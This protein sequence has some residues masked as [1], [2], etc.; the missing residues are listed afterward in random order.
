[1]SDAIDAWHAFWSSAATISA[2]LFGLTLVTALLRVRDSLLPRVQ[3]KTH[4]Y[5]ILRAYGAVTLIGLLVLMPILT[6][7]RL[8]AVI[9]AISAILIVNTSWQIVTSRSG[10]PSPSA[11]HWTFLAPWICYLIVLWASIKLMRGG[12]HSTNW[13]GISA[14]LLLFTGGVLSIDVVRRTD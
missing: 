1:M 4:I 9:A 14:M 3:V 10:N 6:S 13:L 5:Q 12:M 8:G 11:F 7:K 2:I